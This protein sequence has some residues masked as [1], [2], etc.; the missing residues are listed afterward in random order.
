MNVINIIEP[1]KFGSALV[2]DDFSR[3]LDKEPFVCNADTIL[4]AFAKM[5][6]A[7]PERFSLI[8][9]SIAFPG[10]QSIATWVREE[11]SGNTYTIDFGGEEQEFWLCPALLKYFD[12]APKQIFFQIKGS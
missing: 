2:F 6:G 9:S 10:H 12:A 7:N 5:V 8:F 11:G 1:Y 3:G 4:I